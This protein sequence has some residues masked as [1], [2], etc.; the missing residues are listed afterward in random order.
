MDQSF[1]ATA[2][3]VGYI[4]AIAAFRG[5]DLPGIIDQVKMVSS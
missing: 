1:G 2:N 5:K 3:T 4:A